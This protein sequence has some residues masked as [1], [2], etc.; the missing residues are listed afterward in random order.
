MKWTI[1]FYPKIITFIGTLSLGMRPKTR[2]DSCS[3]TGELS[4]HH[5]TIYCF[6]FTTL[7]ISAFFFLPEKI[8]RSSHNALQ[9]LKLQ[10]LSSWIHTHTQGFFFF[11]IA[12]SHAHFRFLRSRTV[13]PT[14]D[15]YQNAT[16]RAS[17]DEKSST[18]R[19]FHSCDTGFYW[20]SENPVHEH[21]IASSSIWIWMKTLQLIAKKQ[22]QKT[23]KN[24]S[25]QL[26]IQL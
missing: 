24:A 6:L 17:W 9:Q 23:K 25:I 2:Y 22:K 11:F 18:S 1:S 19:A 13:L 7:D 3:V 14:I 16:P 4:I 21:F 15:R 20:S 5:I 10:H 12:L 26:W 8:S